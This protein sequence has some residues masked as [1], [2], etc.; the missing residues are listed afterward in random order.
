MTATPRDLVHQTLRFENTARAPRQL[1]VL[2]WAATHYAAEL[3]AIRRDYPDDLVGVDGHL[4]ERPK[5]V[6][7]PCVVGDYQDEWGAVFR[8]IQAGVIGEVKEPLVRDWAT[9]AAR[10]HVPREWLT[11]DR[12]AVNRDCAAT[13]R[14][15]L[16]GT[17]PRPF[18]QLQFLRGTEGL[19]VDLLDQPP[20]LRSFL[21]DMHAFYCELLEVWAA[22]DVDAIMFMD[23]WGS[24]RT[25]LA[26]PQLWREVF[27]PLYRDY[28][29]IAH[30]AGKRALMH[31]DGHILSIY[32]DLVEIGLDAVNSQIFCMGAESLAP[33][34][35]QITFWGEIDRQNLLPHATPDEIDSAVREVH[36]ALWRRGGCIAQCEFGAGARPENVRQVFES[37]DRLTSR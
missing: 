34:A 4:R 21:A 33:F 3:Q 31:S 14:F 17:C 36:G 27:K 11:I 32:P 19:L 22:T 24:Q 23:D 35:G 5:T 20:A 18:E 7:D 9:D 16:A 12:D 26:R 37:W 25:L 2:P 8:N 29:Q 15:T 13:D 30:G 6:G 28:I 1:W 10:V